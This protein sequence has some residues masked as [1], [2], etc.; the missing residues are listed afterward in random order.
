MEFLLVLKTE[1]V[2]YYN[3][4]KSRVLNVINRAKVLMQNAHT[5]GY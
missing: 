1:S 3:Y 5:M 4:H 2:D